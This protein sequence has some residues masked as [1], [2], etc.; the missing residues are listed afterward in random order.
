MEALWVIPL[1][2]IL[3][4][5]GIISL[6]SGFSANR[7]YL[8]IALGILLL[9][10]PLL[11]YALVYWRNNSLENSLP[12]SYMHEP[13]KQVVL[14]LNRDKTFELYKMD[15]FQRS[16]KGN[17]ELINWDMDEVKLKFK[18]SSELKFVVFVD[19]NGQYLAPYSFEGKLRKAPAGNTVFAK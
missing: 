9:S 16:G 17:W 4:L 5:I 1:Y 11:H 12:G 6:F 15:S 8:R 19:S 7:N 18:D 3:P 13:N 10:L 14:S 2:F